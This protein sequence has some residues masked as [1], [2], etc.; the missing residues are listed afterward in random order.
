LEQKNRYQ[1]QEGRDLPMGRRIASKEE[2]WF[3]TTNSLEMDMEFQQRMV[4]WKIFY[5]HACSGQGLAQ[6]PDWKTR[7]PLYMQI[8][9][10]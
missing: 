5:V 1:P 10:R 7:A 8:Q 6:L 9:L 2:Q 3:M 4:D